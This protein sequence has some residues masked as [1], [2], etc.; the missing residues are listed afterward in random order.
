MIKSGEYIQLLIFLEKNSTFLYIYSANN[1]IEIIEGAKRFDELRIL[2]NK[3]KSECENWN[4]YPHKDLTKINLIK[5][6]IIRITKEFKVN[7]HFFEP[8]N[9]SFKKGFHCM[10]TYESVN[11]NDLII[12]NTKRENSHVSH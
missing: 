3:Y 6:D 4:V 8:N 10:Y 9:L 1:N 11:I 5:E 7:V 2:Y 12:F